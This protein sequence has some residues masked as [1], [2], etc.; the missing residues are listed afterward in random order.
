MSTV[1]FRTG[2]VSG[3]GSLIMFQYNQLVPNSLDSISSECISV[4]DPVTF[5]SACGRA[6]MLA[7][8]L[9]DT[10]TALILY[11]TCLSIIHAL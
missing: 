6:A 11:S 8:V 3:Q 4:K 5:K 1:A 9:H 10:D 7:L 2:D